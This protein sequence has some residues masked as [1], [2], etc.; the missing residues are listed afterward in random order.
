[1][2]LNKIFILCIILISIFML[3]VV[4]ASENT[5]DLSIDE[6]NSD[7]LEVQDTAIETKG[8]ENADVNLEDTS[9]VKPQIDYKEHMWKEEKYNITLTLPENYNGKVN[10]K[11]ENNE[12]ES[13]VENGKGIV[14]LPALQT[15]Y[16]Y[17]ISYS[18]IQTYIQYTDNNNGY[19]YS[20]G[21]EVYIHEENPNDTTSITKSTLTNFFMGDEEKIL[22]FEIPYGTGGLIDLYID[23]DFYK[24]LKSNEQAFIYNVPSSLG[25][26][27]HTYKARLYDSSYYDDVNLTGTFNINCIYVE[28]PTE[29]DYHNYGDHKV[30]VRTSENVTGYV[31]I[32]IDGKEYIKELLYDEYNIIPLYDVAE[33]THKGTVVYSGDLNHDPCNIS[34]DYYQMKPTSLEN[35][36]CS[37]STKDAAVGSNITITVTCSDGQTGTIST[38]ANGKTYTSPIISNSATFNIYIDDFD[39]YEFYFDYSGDE[40]H[41]PT[42]FGTV[43]TCT[44]M[45]HYEITAENLLINENHTISI[46]L[47]KDA[48]GN[49]I[50]RTEHE[51]YSLE[52]R[53]GKAEIIIPASN[54]VKTIHAEYSGDD[55]EVKTKDI[56]LIDY[57]ITAPDRMYPGQDE[58]L[59]IE[60]S[61]DY[62]NV[63]VKDGKEVIASGNLT[64]GKF[65]IPLKDFTLEQH[66][67]RI[68]FGEK[69]VYKNV[70]IEPKIIKANSTMIVGDN[71]NIVLILPDDAKGTLTLKNN[72]KIIS[73]TTTKD[74]IVNISL[75]NLTFGSYDLYIDYADEKYGTFYSYLQKINIYK[76]KMS[77]TALDTKDGLI[78]KFSDNV[79]GCVKVNYKNMSYFAFVE[80]GETII[81][82][83]YPVNNISLSYCE[84]DKSRFI[85]NEIIPVEIKTT[86][87]YENEVHFGEDI[88]VFIEASPN[89]NGEI[90]IYDEISEGY[91]YTNF[92]VVNGTGNYTKTNTTCAID[93]DFDI[94]V[95]NILV[96]NVKVL[97]VPKITVTN[98]VIAMIADANP[99]N[100]MVVNMD[101]KFFNNASLATGTATISLAD[102]PAGVHEFEVYCTGFPR[103][104]KTFNV[105]IEKKPTYTPKITCGNLNM[106][107]LDGSKFKVSVVG[108]SG[109]PSAG[110]TV[111]ITINKITYKLKTN[112]NGAVYLKIT[113]LPKVYKITVKYSGVTVTKKVTVKK[114]LTLNTVKVKKSAKKLVLTATLKKGKIPLKNKK[115]TFKFN[116]KKYA[117]K[118]NKKGIAKVTVKK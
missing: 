21:F 108:K 30:K 86:I 5:T 83:L 76:P 7:V 71:N 36:I 113:D 25:A 17:P 15:L 66:S 106:Y 6:S 44:V 107:Y 1:M 72:D 53:G 35:F 89:L 28:G 97:V 78:I 48:N 62:K 18:A 65:S 32:L 85:K 64:N 11:M 67:F 110:E 37:F 103:V 61:D 74:G 51:N 9:T 42:N 46:F 63:T 58:E 105:T 60:L 10:V 98:E 81:P 16:S 13:S 12:F 31:T 87:T 93:Y 73:Q 70:Y 19:T 27:K 4:S 38:Y 75:S 56:T 39:F 29:P 55:Y 2:K 40:R 45:T 82:N 111:S 52:V 91:E 59:L 114:V 23:N 68:T 109:S 115:I 20:K 95:D 43:D 96:G 116:G 24:T 100:Y 41:P 102:V 118:T 54:S 57:R 79:T 77:V 33:G 47:P 69:T 84:N 22:I 49:L 50:V 3:G 94:W 34:F 80:D 26:G 90:L 117:A 88:V 112:K 14:E 104:P 101:G 92:K 8:I 99:N